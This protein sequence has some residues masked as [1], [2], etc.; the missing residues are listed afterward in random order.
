MAAADGALQGTPPGTFDNQPEGL[1]DSSTVSSAAGDGTS[2]V[3]AGT[4]DQITHG[5]YNVTS[6]DCNTCHT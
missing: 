1:V 2:G 5:D 6:Y 4:R 3:L